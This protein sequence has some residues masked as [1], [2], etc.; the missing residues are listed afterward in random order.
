MNNVSPQPTLSRRE[1][2]ILQFLFNGLSTK[3]IAARLFI[4]EHTVSNHRSNML[5]KFEARG[6]CELIAK[7]I[8]LF[9]E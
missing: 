3:Q 1:H 7:N 9:V 6:T 5:K 8:R 2:E 4:S